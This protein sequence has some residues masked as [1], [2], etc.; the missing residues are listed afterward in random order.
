MN[1]LQSFKAFPEFRR[2]PIVSFNLG[3][4]EGIATRFGLVKNEKES[5]SGGLAFVRDIGVPA[6]MVNTVAAEIVFEVNQL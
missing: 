4:E 2:K 6:G 1:R 3:R 5:G